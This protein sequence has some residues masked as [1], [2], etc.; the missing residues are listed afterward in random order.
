[1]TYMLYE[2]WAVDSTGHNELIETTASKKQALEIAQFSLQDGYVSA[3]VYQEDDD[4]ES[5]A[6]ES[7]QNTA[8]D[9]TAD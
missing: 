7:F 1:M 6:I 8:L 2:V 4:G 9:D 3:A 5:V